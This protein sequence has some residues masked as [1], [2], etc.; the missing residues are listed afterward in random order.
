M[1]K[2]HVIL[3][4]I[5]LAVLVLLILTW[6]E[7][8]TP[9]APLQK[10]ERNEDLIKKGEYL[11]KLGDCTACHTASDGPYLAGGYIMETPFGD[12]VGTNLT[13]SAD[14]GIGRWTSEDFYKALTEGVSPPSRHL[15]PAMPYASFHD[16]TRDDSNALYA[17]LMSL[18]AIDKTYAKSNLPFPFNQRAALMGWNLLFFD[19][20]A[21][22][23]NSEGDSDAWKRGQYIV[24]TFGHCAMCHSDL[25]MF[26]GVDK[27]KQM[28]GGNMG[29]LLGP[30]ITAK[31][32]AE[33]G[34]NSVDLKQYLSTG[35]APQGSAFGEMYKVVNFS[36]QYATKDDLDAVV[37][38]LLGD[39][40]L[41]PKKVTINKGND[42]GKAQY[43]SLCASC[44][45][46]DGSGKPHTVIP[47]INNST[48]R[49]P[50][51]TNLIVSILDGLEIQSFPNSEK[52]DA[53]PGF[54]SKLTD[55]E[56]ADL[57]NYLRATWGGLPE[58]ITPQQ[59]EKLR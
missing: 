15:Y 12:I 17:Y 11:A 23:P 37:T 55:Q 24:N 46:A 2:K 9:S 39:K 6:R 1:K 58:D 30:D 32:L 48:I 26:G 21:P 14:H 38:Y 27:S 35:I 54:T 31:G 47:L 43:L 41:E 49:N 56:A 40:P 8:R 18:P 57:V 20:K 7:H 36:M 5:G 3:V 10:V 25:G 53:M 33:R 19:K 52:M 29:R 28:L 4:I 34:W 51:S 22:V 45:A 16:V 50:D 13:P 59:I 42:Q 44:H